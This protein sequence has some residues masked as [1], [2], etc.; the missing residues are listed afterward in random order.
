M[1]RF[2]QSEACF[3]RISMGPWTVMCV[4][5]FGVL[6]H[7]CTDC[8]LR[9]NA[10]LALQFWESV[11]LTTFKRI[12]VTLNLTTKCADF[13][14]RKHVSF[15]SWWALELWCVCWLSAFHC[16]CVQIA[17]CETMQYSSCN[18]ERVSFAL[19]SSEYSSPCEAIST[20]AAITVRVQL[21]L[22]SSE[23]LPREFDQQNACTAHD[24]RRLSS[25]YCMRVHAVAT[26]PCEAMQY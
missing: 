21:S 15:V 16:V 13:D 22:L 8:T 26:E 20:S 6:L 1:R 7:V 9:N 23:Y 4:L 12:L 2:R 25:L 24:S 18:S 5:A 14:S 3:I 10:V 19:F 11:L 17:H